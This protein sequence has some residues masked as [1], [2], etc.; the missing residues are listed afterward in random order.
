MVLRSCSQPKRQVLWKRSAQNPWSRCA[1]RGRLLAPLQL[2]VLLLRHAGQHPRRAVSWRDPALLVQGG[3]AEITAAVTE[4]LL[5]IADTVRGNALVAVGLKATSVTVSAVAA[6]PKER[7]NWSSRKKNRFVALVHAWTKPG[8]V[9]SLLACLRALGHRVLPHRAT[10]F[11]WVKTGSFSHTE[12]RLA[13]SFKISQGKICVPFDRAVA[14]MVLLLLS[15][16]AKGNHALIA[17]VAQNFQ[18][19]KRWLNAPKVVKL[20]RGASGWKG[21]VQSFKKRGRTEFCSTGQ[22]LYGIS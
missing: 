19:D 18:K 21:W 15:L 20:G 16:G 17:G 3:A 2:S 12:T 14:T 4:R 5:F 1:S 11:K 22:L 7:H 13:L 6:V 9:D 10:L 8:G